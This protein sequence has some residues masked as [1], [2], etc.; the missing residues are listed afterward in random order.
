MHL[1]SRF[2]RSPLFR[3][4]AAASLGL[5]LLAGPAVVR[6]DDFWQLNNKAEAYKNA[7]RSDLAAPIWIELMQRSAAAGDWSTAAIYA[8]RLN[9]YYDRI[10]D[11]ET[12]VRFYELENEYWL[13]DGKDWGAVDLER[14]N[15]IRTTV[16]LYASAAE[17]EELLERHTPSGELAKFEPA[18]GL[19]LGIYSEQDPDMGNFFA[20]SES[21]YGKKHAIYLAYSTYGQPFPA[22]Y[23][24]NA[25][26]AGGA[27]QIAW[28][29]LGGL[30]EVEDGAYLREW[31]RRAKASGIPIFLRFAGEM[32]GN[33]TPW[34]D[35]PKRYIEKFRTVA[36]V[37]K[38]EAPNVAMVWSPGDVPRY[39]MAAYYPGDEYVDWVGVSLYTEPYSNGDP[40]HNM[41]AT[42]PIERLDELYSL[43][44]SRKPVML[45]ET[46]VSFHTY[47]NGEDHTDYA[48]L[49]LQRLYEVMPLKYPRLKAI[50][51]FNVDQQMTESKNNYRLRD[52]PAM[53]ELYKNIIRDPYYLT[54]VKTGAKPDNKRAYRGADI[55]FGQST[56]LIPYVRIPDVIIGML[57]YVLNGITVAVQTE[58]PFRLELQAGDVPEGSVMEL[59]VYN[60]A[61]ERVAQKAFGLSSRVSVEID[62]VLQTFE[63]YPVLVDGT[64]LTP[65][66]A[67]FERMG[68]KVEWDEKT[69]TATGRKGDTVVRLTIGQR[70]AYVNGKPVQLDQEARLVNGYTMAPARFVGEAFGG[71][72]SWDGETRTV[73]IDTD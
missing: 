70:T 38:E 9:E 5:M 49:N 65:L 21:I 10:R 63:Q 28:Q 17:D 37:M 64:T 44:A 18:Y 15:Q 46:A 33:W 24:N 11:Y 45:S 40:Q 43:Y 14:A 62:G 52:N 50:T 57:E 56:R 26:E 22:R 54:T 55:P 7:G 1:M 41:K 72:V 6:A 39:S 31:A 48:L 60:K 73:R 42:A 36:R 58:P 66:R 20:R 69:S 13:K 47:A 3:R 25:R 51:Y 16:E 30:D 2:A 34:A 67:I 53:M 8:G 68:A 32:N 59:R 35:T 12:A 4:I 27:L 61:G 29:P 71:L 23:A 19:Y